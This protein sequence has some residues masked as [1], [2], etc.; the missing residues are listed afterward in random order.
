MFETERLEEAVEIFGQPTVTLDVESDRPVAM[1]AARLIDVAPDDAATRISYGVLNLTHR[2]SDE[3]PEPL[4]PG[5]RYRVTVNLKHIAQR[6]PAG[7]SIRLS[8]STV[9]WPLAWPS[10]EPVKL[11]ISPRDSGLVLPIREPRPAEEAALRPFEEPESGR[12]ANIS[13]VQP[14]QEEWT[15][16]RDL[17]HDR[18]TLQVVNDEGTKRYNDIDLDVTAKVTEQYTHSYANHDSLRGWCEW[19]RSCRRGEWE[20]STVTRTLLTADAEAFRIRATLDAYEGD[21][22]VFAHT[23]DRR[24]PRDLV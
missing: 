23:W 21:T 11:T 9:Y 14:T 3:S 8:I 18:T 24:I 19:V 10:P 15:V 1:V 12:P 16:I 20:V 22:R 5:R 4:E 6:F 2:D 17:A 7:H 13:L